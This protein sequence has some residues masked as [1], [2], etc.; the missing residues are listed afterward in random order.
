VPKT[1]KRLPK[2]SNTMEPTQQLCRFL[3]DPGGGN[4]ELN[5]KGDSMDAGSGEKKEGGSDGEGS[6]EMN[7][8]K[9]SVGEGNDETREW[10]VGVGIGEGAGDKVT[11]GVSSHPCGPG[12]FGQ[13]LR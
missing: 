13:V 7:A 3:F 10:D 2:Q 8:G 11:W 12:R 9:G 5:S 6:G 1:A 4:G